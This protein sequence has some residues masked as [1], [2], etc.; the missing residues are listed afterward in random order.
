MN[1]QIWTIMNMS[2]VIDAYLSNWNTSKLLAVHVS[3]YSWCHWL[4]HCYWKAIIKIQLDKNWCP[5]CS[6]D[7][8]TIIIEYALQT[9]VAHFVWASLRLI[10]ILCGFS[11][12]NY[13]T[14]WIHVLLSALLFGYRNK[15]LHPIVEWDC[16]FTQSNLC[17]FS[18]NKL[19]IMCHQHLSISLKTTYKKQGFKE[20]YT[21]RLKERNEY[22]LK[23]SY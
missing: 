18:P 14:I 6:T 5:F 2:N 20:V 4:P 10:H 1:K 23:L 13:I 15:K 19:A 12:Q 22:S 11:P 9:I 17:E 16:Q 8:K 3:L 7:A 21:Q